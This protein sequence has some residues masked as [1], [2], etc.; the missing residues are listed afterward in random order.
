M[1]QKQTYLYWKEWQ[2]VRRVDAK[3]DRHELHIRALGKDKSSKLFN[4]QDLDKVLGAFRAISNPS[5]LNAQLRQLN[6]DKTRL[7]WKIMN[8]QSSLISVFMEGADQLERNTE[9]EHYIIAVI[10]DKFHTEDIRDL[11]AERI[12]DH[13][14]ELEM[15][16]NT[17]DARINDLRKKKDITIHEMRQLAGVACLSSCRTCHPV[18]RFTTQT[19][20]AA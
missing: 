10:R 3:A 11:S 16:R 8:D 13:D 2:A 6:Q 9:A 15:L 7:L 1:T 17:L 5:N 4:N 12:Q 20:V 18:K 14:S 19:M